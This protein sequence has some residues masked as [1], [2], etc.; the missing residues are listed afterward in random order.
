MTATPETSR[1]VELAAGDGI[2]VAPARWSF[3]GDVAGKFDGHVSRSVPLYDSGH[4]LTARLSDYFVRAGST[5]YEIGTST[6]TL[7]RR[8][9][10]RHGDLAETRFIGLDVE[11]DMI[12]HAR[13]AHAD[14][15]NMFFQTAKAENFAFERSDLITAHYTVQFIP[16]KHRQ[17]LFDRIWD[18]LDWGGAFILF[19]KVRANDA[20]FQDAF[21]T[22]Y[23]EF[24]L[25]NG[26]DHREVLAKS[27]SLKG[28]MEPFTSEANVD[29]MR[30]AGF[31]DIITVQK[32]LCFE[33]WLAIK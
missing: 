26:Y 12:A 14:M 1:I 21:T 33:G 13:Q 11:P 7:L 24:K 27:L 17:A 16:P 8:L 25:A 5:V 23:N 19:E 9:A 6:G 20:R 15:P 2:A 28:K 32:Y 30:R 18:A 10:M 3:A 22:L 29:F 4:D 31:T